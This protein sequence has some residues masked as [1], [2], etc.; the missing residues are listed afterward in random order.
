[1]RVRATD[2]RQLFDEKART[3]NAKYLPGGALVGRLAR[4]C[5]AA[6][7]VCPPPGEL[8][9]FGCGT[10]NIARA[11]VGRGY[12]VSACDASA[13]MLSRGRHPSIAMLTPVLWYEAS[14]EVPDLPFDDGSFDVIVASSVFEYLTDPVGSLRELRRILRRTGVLICTVP[15]PVHRVRRLEG[16]LRLLAVRPLI[17]VTS[18]ISSKVGFQLRYLRAS[19]NRMSLG[20]WSELASTA[21]FEGGTAQLDGTSDALLLLVMRGKATEPAGLRELV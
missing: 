20:G 10:G 3:W 16:F 2:V 1:M 12:R 14:S 4:F 9:D 11:L 18:T 15:N 21:G 6:E 8:L 17:R 5:E 7:L 19:H 13:E